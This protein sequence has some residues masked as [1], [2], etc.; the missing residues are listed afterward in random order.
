MPQQD[1]KTEPGGPLKGLTVIDLTWGVAGPLATM[2]MADYGAGVIKVEPPGGDP[3][4]AILPAYTVWQRG[5]QSVTL[6]LKTPAGRAALR[7]MLA[8][9]DV[10]IESFAPAAAQRLGIDYPSLANEFP[11]LICCS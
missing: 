11:R 2:F 7:R 6:N 10:M 9:A 4:R 8:R 1:T 5:K 3:F